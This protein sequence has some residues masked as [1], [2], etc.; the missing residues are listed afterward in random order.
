MTKY[1]A[2]LVLILSQVV[3]ALA[4]IAPPQGAKTSSWKDLL[5]RGRVQEAEEV[6]TKLL[7]SADVLQK[8]EARKC[9]ANVALTGRG[10]V[11]L[12]ADDTGGAMSNSGYQPEAV[13]AALGHIEDGLKLDSQDLSLHQ[14]RLHLLEVSGRYSDMTKAL[15]ESCKSYK[16]PE[17]AEPWMAYTAELFERRQFRASLDLLKVLEKY[18]PN[19]STVIGNIGGVYS[20]LEEDEQAIKYLRRAVE[21]APTDPIDTWNLGRLYDY[22]GRIEL[23]DE[24]YQKSLSLQS[25][26]STRRE[27]LCTYATFVERKLQDSKRACELQ[28]ANCPV[29]KQTACRQAR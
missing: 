28:Q 24:W 10:V 6:C 27:S 18:Y 1:A 4:A 23:A 15:E 17:G 20:M 8:V 19:S 16:G 14:G 2:M 7:S 3:L 29:E 9:L 13:D 12:E 11:T 26:S 22:T 5:K 21:L 25:D